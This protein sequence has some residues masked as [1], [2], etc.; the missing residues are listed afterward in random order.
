M[1]LLGILFD[2]PLLISIVAPNHL[3][4]TEN[5]SKLTSSYAIHK[6]HVVVAG[7]RCDLQITTVH[8]FFGVVLPFVNLLAPAAD[9]K[10]PLRPR[11]IERIGTLA[12]DLHIIQ[13]AFMAEHLNA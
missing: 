12:D 5:G 11:R 10:C 7:Q 8:L 13:F 1:A 4:S 3:L 6:F 9:D 2:I